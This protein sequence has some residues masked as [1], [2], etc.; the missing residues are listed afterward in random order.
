MPGCK[1]NYNRGYTTVFA[2]A[3]DDDRI[4]LWKKPIPRENLI[5]TKNTVVCI[6][7]NTS[8]K[9]RFWEEIRV[10]LPDGELRVENFTYYYL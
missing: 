6:V 5:L 8:L 10:T 2:F 3:S 9:I 4:K 7:L 1:A